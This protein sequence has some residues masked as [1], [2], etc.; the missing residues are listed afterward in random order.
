MNHVLMNK[1]DDELSSAIQYVG[2]D[3]SSAKG[4]WDYPEIIKSQL[5][6]RPDG[7][8]SLPSMDIKLGPGLKIEEVDGVKYLLSTSGALTT[9]TLNPPTGSYKQPIHEPI[10]A[11]TPIQ[12]VLETLFYEILPKLSS[13]YKGDVIKADRNGTDRYNEE[14]VRSGLMPNA[15]YMR[16]YVADRQEPVYIL[17]SG[18]GLVNAESTDGS[19]PGVTPDET[20][21]YVGGTSEYIKVDVV[22]NVITATFTDAGFEKFNSISQLEQEVSKKANQ[23]DLDSIND[24][25]GVHTKYI[26]TVMNDMA[27]LKDTVENLDLSSINNLTTKVES[28]ETEINNKVSKEELTEI[29]NTIV[30]VTDKVTNI[31]NVFNEVDLTELN[32]KVGAL[33][34]ELGSV[35]EDVSYIQTELESKASQESLNELHDKIDVLESKLDGIDLSG[36]E[37][38][39]SKVGAL[40]TELDNKVSKEELQSVKDDIEVIQSNTVTRSDVQDIVS[41]EVAD[42]INNNAALENK[43]QENIVNQITD[44]TN[45]EVQN[46][47]TEVV[48]KVISGNTMT[49]TEGESMVDHIFAGI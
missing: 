10:E 49:D 4:P 38:L 13:V 7:D 40:E 5:C 15:T 25:L 37:E 17:L 41:A 32:S 43:I 1:L 31:E 9:C 21:E 20:I 24:V 36:I 48:E 19:T 16:L 2:G 42:A 30:Q 47:I 45:V 6:A 11:G 29:N 26:N 22:D 8:Q 34:T 14:D 3:I 28:L 35:K 23:S 46:A 12:T 27:E 33:E 44:E 18:H 39:N